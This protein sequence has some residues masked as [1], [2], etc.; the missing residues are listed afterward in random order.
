MV[1]GRDGWGWGRFGEDSPFTSDECG[2]AVGPSSCALA[3]V[4]RLFGVDTP[5]SGRGDL[6]ECRWCSG[7]G[8]L[9]AGYNLRAL[10]VLKVHKMCPNHRTRWWTSLAPHTLG[11]PAFARH[12]EWW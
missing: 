3:D 7:Q 6:H 5:Q 9:H 12:C 4:P 10:R 2:Q 11:C 8:A 1:G